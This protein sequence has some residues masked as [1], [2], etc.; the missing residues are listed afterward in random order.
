[1]NCGLMG[2]QEHQEIAEKTIQ[3]PLNMS[4]S[5]NTNVIAEQVREHDIYVFGVTFVPR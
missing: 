5:V 1:M 4:L 2:I 3:V